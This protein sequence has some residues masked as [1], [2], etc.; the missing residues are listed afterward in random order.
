M[1]SYTG[2]ETISNMAEEA[3][4]PRRLIPRAM[5][6]VVIAV[7]VIYT[8]LPSRRAVGAAGHPGPP[9]ARTRRSSPTSYAGDPILGIVENMNLGVFQ[10]AAEYYVG[11]LAA[12]ILLIA[13][14]AGIIGVSRLTYSMGQ[15][16]QLPDRAPPDQPP[17]PHAGERDPD[18][19]PDRL[20][21]DDPGTGGV[22]GHPLRVRRDAVLH[23]RPHRADRTALAPGAATRCASSRATSR[24]ST[25][26]PG[27][28]RRSTCASA[29]STCRCSRCSAGWAP[30]RPGSP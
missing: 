24:W 3:R 4:E 11:V 27:T 6:L 1:I 15:H 18:L 17:V 13:S 9:T 23:D 21:R 26:R 28:G 8:G 19:R 14:N 16:Q 5:M 7:M 29:A 2:I 25:R 22:P 10:T 20:L 12:T 30:S